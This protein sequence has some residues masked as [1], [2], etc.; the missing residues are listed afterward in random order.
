MSQHPVMT[1]HEPRRAA[2]Q[3]WSLSYSSRNDLVQRQQID[4]NNRRKDS[5]LSVATELLSGATGLQPESD[6]LLVVLHL[7]NPVNFTQSMSS[8]F[9]KI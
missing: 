8:F 1:I 6:R 9:G 2:F 4:Q 3:I 7:S 5:Q